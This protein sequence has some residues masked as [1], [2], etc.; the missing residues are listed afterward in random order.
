MLLVQKYG[1][2]SVGSL[3]RLKNCAQRVI[4]ARE[5]GHQVVVVLSA[6][7][8]DTDRLLKEALELSADPDPRE[9][10]LL[11]ATG[12][13]RSIALLALYLKGQGVPAISL[14]GFQIPILTDGI[15][16][17][18][19][20]QGIGVEKIKK[21]LQKGKVVVVAGFQGTTEDLEITTLG[22]GG[23][24][25]SAVALAAALKADLCEI[26]TDVDGVYTAD[27]RKVPEA[28]LLRKI[29]HEEMMELA[30]SGAKVLQTRSVELAAKHR[31]PVTVRNSFNETAGTSVVAEEASLEKILVAG[32]TL[33]TNEAKVAIRRIPS[34]NGILAKIFS[35][36]A[37]AGVNVDMIV[38]N[39]GS[40][41]TTDL[42][43][44]VAKED[45][46]K[47]MQKVE[48]VAKSLGAGKVEVA[49]DIAKIS[50]V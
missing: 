41:G 20:I 1:G 29:S 47:T 7:A 10:D 27:P 21:E 26:Y 23:S 37:E 17:K 32:I 44:T 43:F 39:L 12:E 4:K 30:D 34:I 49:G 5:E 14:M 35:P 22:R 2:T 6:Q 40:D 24:D 9:Y 36:L 13:Q 31:V 48:S 28:K 15:H 45:L 3:E 42:A 50:V 8:G 25:T 16:T 19:R 46:K 33:N 38:E 18:A 11:L